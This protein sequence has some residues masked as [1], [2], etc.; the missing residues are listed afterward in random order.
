MKS[1][2]KKFFENY[3]I[4]S[5]KYESSLPYLFKRTTGSFY[6]G[7]ELAYKMVNEMFKEIASNKVTNSKILEPCN[8]TGMFVFAILKY[9]LDNNYKPKDII[10]VI[11]NIY[12]S[13]VNNEANK[14]YIKHLKAFTNEILNYNLDQEYFEKHIFDYLN[15]DITNLD[16][17]YISIN[18]YTDIKFDIVITNPPYKNLKLDSKEYNKDLSKK[19]KEYY[20]RISKDAKRRFSYASSGVINIYK[21]F[22][23]EILCNYTDDN[24]IV[25]LLIPNTI[26]SDKSCEELRKYLLENHKIISINTFD[27]NN[28]YLDAQQALC[29]ILIK[30]NNKTTKIIMVN[31]DEKEKYKA[32]INLLMKVQSG[33]SIFKLNDYEE[34]VLTKLSCF[35]KLKDLD[36]IFNYRGEL[37]LTLYKDEYG[38]EKTKYPLVR[39]RNIRE[40]F[41]IV[42]AVEY[43]FDSFV[44]NSPKKDYIH[45]ERIACQQISNISKEKRVQFAYIPKDNVLANSCNFIS[46]KKN[47]YNIDIYYLLGLLNSNIINWFFKFFNSNNHISNYEIDEFP[48]PVE[49]KQIKKIS[50]FTKKMILEHD[51]SMK[52]KINNLVDELYGINTQLSLDDYEAISK[53]AP[54]K[55]SLINDFYND[56]KNIILEITYNECIELIKEQNTTE[57]ILLKYAIKD[58]FVKEVILGLIIKYQKIYKNEILNHTTFKLSDLDLEMIQNVPQGGNWQNIPEITVKKSE[59]LKK[60]AKTGGRTTLYGR[61]DYNKPAYTITTYFN[62]PGNGTYVHPV[63]NRVISVREAA[64]FQSFDDSYYFYG[65]KTSLLKQ[66]GNAVPVLLGEAIGKQIVKKTGLNKSLDLFCGAGG[67]TSGFRKAGIKSVMGTDFDKNACITFKINNTESNTLCADI[68]KDETKKQIIEYINQNNV[69]IICGG[70]PCQG[71]S[72]AGKR[73]ID[74]PRNQLF[75]D[76]IYIVNKVRP[77][78]V[79]MENVEGLLTFQN[80]EIYNQIISLYKEMGY[81][82]EGR[83][84]LASEYGVPQKRKRV[85]IIAIKKELQ[86]EPSDLFPIKTT[87][88]V[89]NMINASQAIRDLENIECSEIA[90]YKFEPNKNN[91]YL[92]YLLSVFKKNKE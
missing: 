38:T 75:K 91:N 30:K 36:F 73:F 53:S 55:D 22:I 54:K 43:V 14:F 67:L 17:K 28:K 34:Y 9:L 33:N 64:R 87:E 7:F 71:F 82:V 79:I 74:D 56:L 31:N 27:E 19:Y 78:L 15:Y 6:T 72:L 86:I 47:K 60:I 8:G 10:S 88:N 11:N 69:D 16:K 59:R 18:K 81:K 40:Y 24:A 12:I 45:N 58:N 90:K 25:H 32:D 84:L 41:E 57:N 77:K 29:T 39:G 80:G 21:I 20:A 61:I 5:K 1:E 83:L 52:Q 26:L 48:I 68:T 66:V 76:Y 44:E 89:E 70:P 85:I 65:N 50:S 3:I 2:I 4:D 92:D 63:H 42:D 51:L 23:E 62:R 35:P 37:D 13:E 46:I 49:G